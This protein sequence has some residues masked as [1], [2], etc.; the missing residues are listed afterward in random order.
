MYLTDITKFW[1]NIPR[2]GHHNRP[3]LRPCNIII[4]KNSILFT[5][6]SSGPIKRATRS[7]STFHQSHAAQDF[8]LHTTHFQPLSFLAT[9]S[10]MQG[11]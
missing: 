10:S 6:L 1:V 2:F 4:I 7:N 5:K 8:V 9:V 11:A 3:I